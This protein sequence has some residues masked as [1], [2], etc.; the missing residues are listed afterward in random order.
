MVVRSGFSNPFKGKVQYF[1]GKK[2]KK[3]NH[4]FTGCHQRVFSLLLYRQHMQTDLNA[5][6]SLTVPSLSPHPAPL[7]LLDGT[8]CCPQP[9]PSTWLHGAKVPTIQQQSGF[10]QFYLQY[11]V[12]FCLLPSLPWVQVFCSSISLFL[13]WAGCVM[14]IT[15]C[16]ITTLLIQVLSIKQQSRNGL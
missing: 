6:P 9:E 8:W 10:C 12:A 13:L 16:E 1:G 3:K 5:S 7:E 4:C 11:L 14:V 2:K 15:L